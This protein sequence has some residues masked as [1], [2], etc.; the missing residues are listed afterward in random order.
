LDRAVRIGHDWAE[1][2][3]KAMTIPRKGTGIVLSAALMVAGGTA[4]AGVVDFDYLGNGLGQRVRFEFQAEVNRV[5]TGQREWL[6]SNDGGGFLQGGHSIRT[7]SFD[8]LREAQDGPYQIRDWDD[9]RGSVSGTRI[10]A[11]KRSMIE[12]LF[13]SH[14]GAVANADSKKRVTAFQVAIWEITYEK[15]GKRF[16]LG[17]G[18]FQVIEISENARRLANRWLADVLEAYQ[19]DTLD[20]FGSLYAALSDE[21]ENQLL[22]IP[23]PPAA[24]LGA[25][26]IVGLAVLP[27]RRR[28]ESSP[29]F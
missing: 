18:K 1:G 3:E 17:N 22:V 2:E 25:A 27:R 8:V 14:Y 6:T 23:A 28:T 11:A 9:V 20:D 10:N 13:A 26:G 4:Q 19:A 16:S 24:L 21:G 15:K 5:K 7:F 29:S 12:H